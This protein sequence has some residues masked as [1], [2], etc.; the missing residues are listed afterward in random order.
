MSHIEW[1]E[2]TPV[3]ASKDNDVDEHFP[4]SCIK[5]LELKSVLNKDIFLSAKLEHQGTSET[6]C[7]GAN[8]VLA[9]CPSSW[10]ATT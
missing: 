3:C 9:K 10:I 7:T 6:A 4:K 8:K 5:T 2:F 1:N